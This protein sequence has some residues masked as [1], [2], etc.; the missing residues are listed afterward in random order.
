LADQI[1]GQWQ[2]LGVA[3]YLDDTIRTTPLSNDIDK[4]HSIIGVADFDNPQLLRTFTPVICRIDGDDAY[5]LP[6]Q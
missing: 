2:R 3:T 4:L 5:R 6:A 1:E